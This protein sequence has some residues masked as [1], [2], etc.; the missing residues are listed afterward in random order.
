MSATRDS[1]VDAQGV[2]LRV[3]VAGV[4]QP[5]MPVLVLHGFTG[6]IESMA[7]VVEAL[8]DER[9]VVALDLI[10]HGESDAPESAAAYTMESSVAQV[11]AV[12][13]ALGHDRVH[14]IGYSM[15]GRVALSLCV[16]RPEKVASLLLVGVSPGIADPEARAARVEAD[17][18][19]ANRIL[20]GGLE[21]FVDEWMVQPL[22]ATQRVLGTEAWGRARRQRLRCRPAGLAGSLRGMG[23]GAMPPLHDRLREIEAQVCL[24]A[25]SLDEKFVLL[26][27]EMEAHLSHGRRELIEGVGHAAHLEDPETFARMAG[28]FL[29][30]I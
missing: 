12:L 13:D 2:R 19:L 9:P 16:A 1:F 27:R 10:G 30:A 29:A 4:G 15:G 14:A 23:T 6:S 25:G 11:A 18:D 21:R 7:G 24:V 3:R 22:F 8:A 26:A 20:E 5:G 17:E 28:A